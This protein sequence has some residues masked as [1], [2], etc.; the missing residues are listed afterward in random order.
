MSALYNLEIHYA[1]AFL[2]FILF[3]NNIHL[4]LISSLIVHV[5]ECKL[6]FPDIKC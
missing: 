4:C 5:V 6:V 1:K 2:Y 3:N